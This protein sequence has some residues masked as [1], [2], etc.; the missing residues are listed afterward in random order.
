MQYF[1]DGGISHAATNVHGSMGENLDSCAN[2][3]GPLA[4]IINKDFVRKII[5]LGIWYKH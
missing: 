4:D 2:H 1:H 5:F 3:L